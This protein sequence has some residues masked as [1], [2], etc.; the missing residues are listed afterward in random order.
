MHRLVEHYGLVPAQVAG[1]S[2]GELLAAHVAG[3]VALEDAL[4]L[5]AVRGRLAQSLPS[6]T[7]VAVRADEQRVRAALANRRSEAAVAAVNAPGQTV[8]SGTRDAVLD[9]AVRWRG[10]G[11]HVT[12]LASCHAL[13]SPLAEPI[14][15]ALAATAAE[16]VYR[17]P[18]IPVISTTGGPEAAST[19][20]ATPGHWVSHA[21]AAVR[22]LDGV[23]AL[24]DAGATTML[25]IGPSPVLTPLAR[26]TL[27]PGSHHLI[28]LQRP[29]RPET[30]S[31]LAGLAAAHVA[32]ATVA[33][34]A[35]HASSRSGED[36]VPTYP[37]Q[38]SAYWHVRPPSGGGVK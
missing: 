32:G 1:H 26:R 34:R 33:W 17:Q 14:L 37:F 22:F 19:D 23:R 12:P 20:I 6:A 21:R 24:H 25:E 18:R 2:V 3:V 7:A 28:A 30:E 8:V 15:D 27:G 5:V 10:E 35:H 31:F 16:I 9:L 4:K 29:G 11:L 36:T 13:H 38:S